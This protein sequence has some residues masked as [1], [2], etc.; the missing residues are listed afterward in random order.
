VDDD[1]SA[2]GS[3]LVYFRCFN[4]DELE[5]LGIGIVEGDRPGSNNSYAEL[6]GDIDEANEAA[7]ELGLRILFRRIAD[8]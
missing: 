1:S 4:H 3:A 5:E 8:L 2:Q 6:K 7:A